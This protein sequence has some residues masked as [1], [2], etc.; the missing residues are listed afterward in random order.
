MATTEMAVRCRC[1]RPR[2]GGC[3]LGSPERVTMAEV[4]SAR[5]AATAVRRGPFPMCAYNT[6]IKHIS[7]S[8]SEICL[9]NFME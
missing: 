6:Q 8:E 3:T 1:G 4:S 9:G 5:I 7:S 2:R